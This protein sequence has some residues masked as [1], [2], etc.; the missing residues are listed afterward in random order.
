MDIGRR[1]AVARVVAGLTQRDLAARLG[2]TREYLARLE[3]ARQPVSLRLLVRAATALGAPASAL[4]RPSNE[5]T[6][7]MD[8]RLRPRTEREEEIAKAYGSASYHNA[9]RDVVALMHGEDFEPTHSP[10]RRKLRR[11]ALGALDERDV[12]IARMA[13]S[14]TLRV[15]RERQRSDKR[16]PRQLTVPI[17]RLEVS[18]RAKVRPKVRQRT[19]RRLRD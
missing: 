3:T 10:T 7:V 4:L 15:C 13:A 9:I 17:R 18:V 1:I 19:R 14:A 16:I 8:P 12:R 2:V 6:L 11:E 5:E